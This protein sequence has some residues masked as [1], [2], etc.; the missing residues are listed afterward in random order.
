[1]KFTRKI[2]GQ[3]SR[4]QK[5][6]RHVL[7]G[8][9]LFRDRWRGQ[10]LEAIDLIPAPV[11]FRMPAKTQGKPILDVTEKGI[12]HRRGKQGEKQGQNLAARDHA[13]GGAA[14]PGV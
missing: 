2:Q 12:E 3:G 11:D 4:L 9:G 7:D 6:R 13:R 1:M 5:A 10:W 14:G 8:A